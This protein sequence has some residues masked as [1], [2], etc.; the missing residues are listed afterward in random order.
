VR[1]ELEAMRLATNPRALRRELHALLEELWRLPNATPGCT[2]DVFA[3]LYDP[4]I[5]EEGGGSPR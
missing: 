3:T 5:L 4:S 1:Q 2:E